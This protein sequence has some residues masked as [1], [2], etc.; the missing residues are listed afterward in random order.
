MD[1]CFE[2][3]LENF[4]PQFNKVQPLPSDIKKFRG[5]LPDKLLE[6]WQDHNWGGFHN[7]LFWLVN[8][9]DY[10]RVVDAWL[11]NTGIEGVDS[12]FAIARTAFGRVFLWN[13]STGQT[14]TISGLFSE[15]ITTPPNRSVLA[16][17][18]VS[19]VEAFMATKEP[20]ALDIE[21]EKEKKIF[22]RAVKKLGALRAD[23][24]YGFEP[25]LVIGGAPKLDNL[26]KVKVIEH[27]ILLQQFGKIE[28]LH[29]D[30]SRHL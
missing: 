4:G 23:E 16:G 17:D 30:V 9:S 3:F 25:A 7:G 8:P 20:D 2:Y 1:E 27:L 5:K 26:V 10:T 12:Y 14:A 15:I 13:K 28:I 24:M 6:Y 19:A 18:E 11:S 21:D 22:K 29:M